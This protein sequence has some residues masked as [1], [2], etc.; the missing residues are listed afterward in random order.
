MPR[1]RELQNASAQDLVASLTQ[2]RFH[3]RAHPTGAMK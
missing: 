2:V 1:F 3:S